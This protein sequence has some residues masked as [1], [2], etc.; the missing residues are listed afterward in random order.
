MVW[1]ERNPLLRMSSISTRPITPPWCSPRASPARAKL[2]LASIS[3]RSAVR[4]AG[5]SR[6]APHI[7]PCK[8]RLAWLGQTSSNSGGRPVATQPAIRVI[9]T[10]APITPGQEISRAA[11]NPWDPSMRLPITID[12]SATGQVSC[13]SSCVPQPRAT[14]G[15]AM[16]T[17]RI[18]MRDQLRSVRSSRSSTTMAMASIQSPLHSS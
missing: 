6:N 17:R 12:H 1:A 5:I 2:G 13:R 14:Q 18:S 7:T 15:P 8:R 11:L 3:S 4:G 16:A 10:V 9:H